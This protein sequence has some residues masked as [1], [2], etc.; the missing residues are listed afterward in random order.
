M[1]YIDSIRVNGQLASG[2]ESP[3]VAGLRPLITWEYDGF[4]EY[5]KDF[6]LR[7]STVSDLWG[8]DYFG[9]DIAYKPY[10]ENPST[11]GSY[12]IE[13]K[14]AK[15][16]TR[17][18]Q[19]FG[20]VQGYNENDQITGWVKFSFIINS[21]PYLGEYYIEPSSP[22]S[23]DNLEVLYSYIDDSGHEEVGT[24][25]RWLKD[26]IYQ[27]EYD[28][29]CVLPSSAIHAGEYWSARI[30]P[31]DGLEYG[32]A[33]ETS[34]AFIL[35]ADSGDPN[36][37]VYFS[38]VRIKPD[39]PN[40]DDILKVEYALAS[41]EYSD[42]TGTVDVQ[43]YLND[44]AIT[45]SN[46]TYIRP[47]LSVGDAI[48]VVATLRDGETLV[49]QMT[50]DSVIIEDVPWYAY[51]I[52]INGL[53]EPI[54]IT[55]MTPTVEWKIEKTTAEPGDVP[56]YL[57]LK[58]TKTP[59]LDGAIYDSGYVEYRTGSYII[60]EGVLEHGRGYY[61]HVAVAD[62]T[63]ISNE[64]Y[65]TV[66]MITAG[67]SWSDY[68]NNATGW[69]IE[70]IMGLKSSTTDSSQGVYIHDGTKFCIV[71]FYPRKIKFISQQLVE[72]S[73]ASDELSLSG[74][75][76]NFRISGQGS[77]IKIVMDNK[78]VVDATG[79]FAYPTSLKYI[80]YGD[81]NRENIGVTGPGSTGPV[82]ITVSEGYW[83]SFRFSTAGAFDIGDNLPGRDDLYFYTVGQ[84]KDGSI[85][86]SESGLLT[87][88]PHDS[89]Q[90][91]KLVSFHPEADEITLSTVTKNFS[92]ITCVYVDK[93]RNKYIG[94]ANGLNVIYGEKH[95]PD[96]EFRT[97][98]AD[99]KIS[100]EDF[101]RISTVPKSKLQL[102]EPN[103][104]TGWFTIDTT[105]RA[106]GEIQET[107]S[108]H[109]KEVRIGCF[110]ESRQGTTNY[111]IGA[112]AMS[113]VRNVIASVT[114]DYE[115][116][117]T[118]HET[119]ILTHSFLENID[120]L[121]L[122]MSQDSSTNIV[123]LDSGEQDALL[124][125][126]GRNGQV[127]C[128]LSDVAEDASRDATNNSLLSVFGMAAT[129]RQD[130]S[131]PN[132]VLTPVGF[133]DVTG[134][135]YGTLTGTAGEFTIPGAPFPAPTTNIANMGGGAVILR[136]DEDAPYR[137]LIVGATSG[138]LMTY[139]FY[140]EQFLSNAI[141]HLIGYAKP[142]LL[143]EYYDP[144]A[145]ESTVRSHAIHYYSQ[146]THGHAWFD[147]VDNTNGW[148]V[149]FDFKLDTA[150]QDDAA[151]FKTT[152]SYASFGEEESGKTL[153][154]SMSDFSGIQG[155]ANL[156]YGH[157]S[158]VFTGSNFTP[159][160][161]FANGQWSEGDDSI[162][163][164]GVSPGSSAVAI[165]WTSNFSGPLGF[166]ATFA[167]E[168]AGIVFGIYHYHGT[169]LDT[170]YTF[171]T[172]AGPPPDTY[173]RI[174]LSELLVNVNSGDIIYVTCANPGPI[175]LDYNQLMGFRIVA[176]D[177][178][179]LE[180]F[181]TVG[182]AY[183]GGGQLKVLDEECF[184]GVGQAWYGQK[185]NIKNGFEVTFEYDCWAECY[186][187]NDG[188]A[189]VI[190][191]NSSADPGV[192]WYGGQ[193]AYG[194]ITNS[195]AVEFDSYRN[196]KY[197]DPSVPH[198]SIQSKGRLFNYPHHNFSLGYTTGIPS[199]QGR[200]RRVRVRYLP[201]YMQVFLDDL[202]VPV[203]TARVNLS[204][205]LDIDEGAYI[206]FTAS[207]GEV[208]GNFAVSN[209]VFSEAEASLVNREGFGIYVNDGMYQEMIYFYPDRL[210]LFHANVY[211]PLETT[212]ERQYRIVGKGKN[213][214]IYEKP[215]GTAVGAWRLALNGA[216]LFTEPAT[217]AGNGGR[218][219]IAMDSH[220]NYHCV[221]HDD[222]NGRSAIL[223]SRFAN[224]EWSRPETITSSNQFYT[225]NPEIAI[226]SHDRL[227]VVYED[228]SWGRPEISCSV[229]DSIGWNPKIRITNFRSEKENPTVTIDSLNNVHVAWSDNR[230]G[231]W[232]VFWAWWKDS[233]KAW[234]SSNYFGSD[235]CIARQNDS[236]T[237]SYQVTSFRRP[238]LAALYPYVW[239]V[240][241]GYDTTL[242]V[243]A[244]Y[245][246]KY[247]IETE[248][249]NS[250]GSEIL[251]DGEF[252][253][254][255]QSIICSRTNGFCVN[256]TI[257]IAPNKPNP[258]IIAW[259][260]RKPEAS[261]IYSTAI[262]QTGSVFLPPTNMTADLGLI[263]RDSYNP[264]I[265][266]HGT[267][268]NL[269]FETRNKQGGTDIRQ[270]NWVVQSWAWNQT[271][272]LYS[273]DEMA[274]TQP[275][276]PYV[277]ADN[278]YKVAFAYSRQP[279]YDLADREEEYFQKIAEIST[280]SGGDSDDPITIDSHDPK[281][282][283]FGD[284]SENVGI[285]AHWRDIR[286]YFGYDARP[287][288]IVSYNH[289]LISKFPDNRINDV[290]ADTYGNIV[291]ATYGGLVYQNVYTG[292]T[293]LI[294]GQEGGLFNKK[295]VTSV[296]WGK[297]GIW[298]VG[299]I[300]GLYYTLTA[301]QTW[302][303]APT[304]P[305]PV[306]D[307]SISQEGAAIVATNDCIYTYNPLVS[308]SAVDHLDF[309]GM[310][311]SFSGKVRA[312]AIDDANVIWAGTDV[313]LVRLDNFSINNLIL[314][315]RKNGMRSN[316][317][318]SIAVVSRYLR[319]I[320]TANGIHRMHG[321]RFYDLSVRTHD[322]Q[323]NNI[324]TLRWEEST[325]SL[326][327][328]SLYKLHE[329]VFRDPAYEIIADEVTHYDNCGELSTQ[330]YYDKRRYD[331]LDTYEIP[332]G[333]SIN[334]EALQ[335]YVN[336][337]PIDFGYAL[338]DGNSSLEF[339]CDMLPDDEV[340]V[341]ISGKFN[342]EYEFEHGSSI[343]TGGT[344]GE[345]HSSKQLV[346]TNDEEGN[347]LL[348]YA[349]QYRLPFTTVLLDRDKPTACIALLDFLAGNQAKF[350]IDAAD[351]TSGIA[352]YMMSNFANFTS[353]GDTPLSYNQLPS[354]GIVY[355]TIDVN[356]NQ[357]IT[358]LS[359]VGCTGSCMTEW[360]DADGKKRLLVA[361]KNPA[362]IYSYH[363]DDTEQEW[364]WA[365]V[366]TL[367]HGN[368]GTVVN[369]LYVH[370]NTI[371]VL[372]GNEGGTGVLYISADGESFDIAGGT[373]AKHFRDVAI[374]D[375][376]MMWISDSDGNIWRYSQDGHAIEFVKIY[377][378]IGVDARSLSAWKNFLI[379]G[380]YNKGKVYLLDSSDV[381]LTSLVIYDGVETSIDR[382]FIRDSSVDN[383]KDAIIYFGCDE[384]TTVYRGN[385][386][387][388]D[389]VK[390][391][392][393]YN[394]NVG[395]IKLSDVSVF[396]GASGPTNRTTTSV[397]D[398]IYKHTEPNWEFVYKHAEDIRDFLVTD[399][400][401]DN[402]LWTVSASR[403][404]K[405]I[406]GSTMKTVYLKVIDKAGNE[407]PTPVLD[408][409]HPCPDPTL[410]PEDPMYNKCCDYLYSI[411]IQ[412]LQALTGASSIVDID[413]NGNVIFSRSSP[414]NRMY[415]SAHM[416]DEEIGIYT[417]DILNGS[418]DLISWKSMWWAANT[419]TGTSIEMQIRYASNEDD[420]LDQSWSDTLVP[421]LNGVV[422]LTHVTLQYLQFRAI[423]KSTVRGISPSLSSVVIRN[424]TSQSSHFYTTNFILPS[425]PIKGLLTANTII[426]VTADIVF[427][428]NTKGSTDFGNYQI[429]EPN[430]IFSTSQAQF[431][432]SIK[433]GVKLL[434]PAIAE[435]NASNNP[436]D[437][438]DAAS[439]V[440]DVAF[441]HTNTSSQTYDWHYMVEFFNDPLRTQKMYEFFTGNDQTG[442]SYNEGEPSRFPATGLTLVP[443]EQAYISF[444]P[445]GQIDENQ[446]WYVTVWAYDGINDP[447]LLG[448]DMSY[449]CSE[450]LITNEIGFIADY[451]KTGL[452]DLQSVPTY[453]G[454]TPDHEIVETQINF[455][456]TGGNN[457]WKTSGGEELTGFDK[458]YAAR[459][460]GKLHAPVAG[461][462]GFI[463]KSINGSLLFINSELVIDHST[464]HA[465]TAS[466][467]ATVYL[468]QGL[469][470][471]EVHYFKGTDAPNTETP[472]RLELWWIPPGETIPSL[473]PAERFY[474]AVAT[475][476]AGEN[477]PIL[478]NLAIMFELENG[479]TIKINLDR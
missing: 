297:N 219:R 139:P 460:I 357:T 321:S 411:S 351:A 146:R 380:T 26:N 410:P 157:Y 119:T 427:G 65:T 170:V 282:F 164:C 180:N 111:L 213:L 37:T 68:V 341:R 106:I 293:T 81:V 103:Y 32:P 318:T 458:D 290:F 466:D 465:F 305:G 20:Q 49:T 455:N 309:T 239:M 310:V 122:C 288:S 285:I 261:S 107:V 395:P 108:Y 237:P 362:Y 216:G 147:R 420:I 77:D 52:E 228:N 475:E 199:L 95:D 18:T 48:K 207:S 124:W 28:D 334:S 389:F 440:C 378:N 360:A 443:S 347:S 177:S 144:Y 451:Y 223:Y 27:P 118:Y 454:L 350:R 145:S 155:Y 47:R 198:I 142:E 353:D 331:F 179:S 21:L 270:A 60:P 337:N 361:T 429:I 468:A 190:H 308:V 101:D 185:L 371:F 435:I 41:T 414:N 386:E 394:A 424:I 92:P 59:S 255:G 471:F 196:T 271:V 191:T 33:V 373:S 283:A 428:F 134:G 442:W 227:W 188:F 233:S 396:G 438:Y 264:S 182:A 263:Q 232:N 385:L 436:G 328:G 404:A 431:G 187:P 279:S 354:D 218:P 384:S 326:W 136:N 79:L 333:L 7:I 256:P 234:M 104:K 137:N 54:G 325:R 153:V 97:D 412:E 381:N 204:S 99:V 358:V 397:G 478:Y 220:G 148:Q 158:G 418:N 109:A 474:H 123:A 36:A 423:L 236:N 93:A 63:P 448:S 422:D 392:A 240:C 372:T 409:E 192:V 401:G 167:A 379:V 98:A 206:G 393:S 3:T 447:I 294:E 449:V 319:F 128:V 160:T 405:K 24:K 450:G 62:S 71:L 421:G 50:S 143:S 1:A 238:K 336:R 12:Q 408:P 304:I 149:A 390:S 8:T 244:I 280:A 470:T 43:W 222:G 467:V 102:A 446:K 299:A 130:F 224:D 274:V 138:I 464:K 330:Q 40:V 311:P 114:G 335:V 186:G 415:F 35:E 169:T 121:F 324:A 298:Y 22:R 252:Y 286:M 444:Q 15:Y 400:D 45:D 349:G 259:E 209:L 382:M 367:D 269:V 284:L 278:H 127:F 140:G 87:W 363:F 266:F 194:G 402:N 432:K 51:D 76:K 132:T 320:G 417:S 327:V 348:I 4:G 184:Y 183:V 235:I 463:L 23:T 208:S 14:S 70:F 243:S 317:V 171:T 53:Q 88:T 58:V 6:E 342:V 377:Q 437:P 193:M 166:T 29:L 163:Q 277:T 221:W 39:Q 112:S 456:A 268:A 315:S 173:R 434:S 364:V 75:M 339:L 439:Y 150:E 248:T 457:W 115:I 16:L 5:Q 195:I 370:D 426:P 383:A 42:I 31:C 344:V 462:Y 469:H 133:E 291:I 151:S 430:R 80:E 452:V 38:Y 376:G 403:V 262:M 375:S 55:E 17:N 200:G 69:T 56:A 296:K 78:L 110:S 229:R 477:L 231:D 368:A 343:K 64:Y 356:L 472:G 44:I 473:V 355:H 10:G 323:N 275:S 181:V 197:N 131:F 332:S 425:R 217:V 391:Y 359:F 90:P 453:S 388:L 215:V 201:G 267:M 260:D 2:D 246:G 72:Y 105:Y 253:A 189:F 316:Y 365:L 272:L 366:D 387:D 302:V 399:V 86:S 419:P 212:K 265:G 154:D 202:F 116:N 66:K 73:Y 245:L 129:G 89:T 441:Y 13:A 258:I 83:R 461:D 273:S 34:P 312:V 94:T 82:Q 120:I 352:G 126:M 313:G 168:A 251:Q 413:E 281:E 289:E 210:R 159:F 25:I 398:R 476:Y 141:Y 287:M 292:T 178:N 214:S 156:N 85:L 203:L 9:Y 11:T 46:Q 329:I 84:L 459:M 61:V 19:Y 303:K 433:V 307:I 249:W 345:E 174:E 162:E 242:N 306:N 175:V 125:Y 301:G 96:Y 416:I 176:K 338:G 406:G 230:N 165:S 241:E 30:T 74:T 135:P 172:T 211:T 205:L 445:L 247:D 161:T 322:I 67:A 276:V 254:Y 226:D 117:T 250:I 295:V 113:R 100:H 346:L 340:T 257:A 152:L 479:E 57:H 225:K 314:Y 374:T 300:D 369:K 91:G 407:T